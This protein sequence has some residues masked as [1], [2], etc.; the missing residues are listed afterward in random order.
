MTARLS[1]SAEVSNL[2]HGTDGNPVAS[3]M[4]CG[5]CSGTCPSV[6]F[7]EYSPREVIAMIRADQRERVLSSNT[8][9]C[10]AS[11]YYCTARC[12]RGIDVADLM[13]A[14]K[15]Y[16][17]WRRRYKRNLI[18]PDFSKRF[19]KTI[20]RTGRSFEPALAP[21]F[22]FRNGPGGLA[23]DISNAIGLFLRGRL[24]LVPSRVKR[25]KNLRSVLARILPLGGYT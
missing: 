3:C 6:D 2:V 20:L 24:P 25:I 16:S 14:L 1:F 7:M 4:Q 15:R 9:W 12:P 13:Y 17:L 10:C 22:I 21:S 19:V 23:C 11:C 18:G 8:F 5:T